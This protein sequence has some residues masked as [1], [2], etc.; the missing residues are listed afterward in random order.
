MIQP[1]ASFG[2][3]REQ[4]NTNLS[5]SISLSLFDQNGNEILIE[6]NPT[7]PIELFIPRDPNVLIPPMIKQNLTLTLPLTPHHHLFNLH[8]VNISSSLPVSVHVELQPDQSNI[9]YL[10]IYKFD[11]S[12]LLN[13]SMKDIDGWT[14]LCS[15][16]EI[17]CCSS[18]VSRLNVI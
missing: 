9:S 16:G 8:Y 18:L 12:P 3:A 14:V 10:L 13:S 2:N 5:R 17:V 4:T 15:S 6:T 7:D 11:R 1:L